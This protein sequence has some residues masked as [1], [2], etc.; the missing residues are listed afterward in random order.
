MY[1]GVVLHSLKKSAGESNAMFS[2]LGQNFR[3]S[4]NLER[5]LGWYVGSHDH[6][7]SAYVDA[8]KQEAC[9][10]LNFSSAWKSW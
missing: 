4:E 6:A 8:Q 2:Y 10:C 9:F 3:R 1:V 7:E 5:Q